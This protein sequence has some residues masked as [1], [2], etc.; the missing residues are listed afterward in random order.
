MDVQSAVRAVGQLLEDLLG[1][2]LG[3]VEMLRFTGGQV[4]LLLSL[5]EGLF[6]H[7]RFAGGAG[8]QVARGR[9]G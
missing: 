3:G 1:L 2:T 5:A 9:G 6:D 7:R 4:Q 8:Q